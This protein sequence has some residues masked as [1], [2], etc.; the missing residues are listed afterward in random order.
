MAE[1]GK[2]PLTPMQ[3]QAAGA[4]AG[5]GLDTAEGGNT[6]INQPT[7]HNSRTTEDGTG[8]DVPPHLGAGQA[9]SQPR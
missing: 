9:A 5:K 2:K 3:A 1:A 7:V 4:G 6:T 8:R